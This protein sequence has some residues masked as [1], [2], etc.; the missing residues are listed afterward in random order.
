MTTAGEEEGVQLWKK[1]IF[2]SSN[3]PTICYCR[4]CNLYSWGAAVAALHRLV[5]PRL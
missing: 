1:C 3:Q 4:D 2:K 5:R